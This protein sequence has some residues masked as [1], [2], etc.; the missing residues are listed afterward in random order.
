MLSFFTNPRPKEGIVA[1]VALAGFTWLAKLRGALQVAAI[2]PSFA[3]AVLTASFQATLLQAY[4]AFRALSVFRARLLFG[5]CTGERKETECD[6]RQDVG[7]YFS[8][9]SLYLLCFFGGVIGSSDR[10]DRS[11][12]CNRYRSRR[13]RRLCLFLQAWV[14]SDLCRLPMHR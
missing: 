11:N 10:L 4:L 8:H 6:D 1:I 14:R 12:H 13:C 3:I 2:L 7:V 5:C 9:N